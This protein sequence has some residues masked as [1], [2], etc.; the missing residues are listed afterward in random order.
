[1]KVKKK[2]RAVLFDLDGTLLNSI[3]LIKHCFEKVFADFGI[4][5]G[6]GEVM[7]TVGLPL[8]QAAEI[9]AQGREEQFLKAYTE[10]YHDHQA[11]MLEL[12]PGTAET[13]DAL[14]GAGY[15]L[16]LVTSKRRE[17]AVSGMSMTGLDRYISQVVALEDTSRP[18][19]YPDCLLRGLELLEVKPGQAVYVGDSWYDVLTG[20]N[21]GVATAGV[22]WGIASREE[23][24]PYR[25]DLIAD[26]WKQLLDAM[27]SMGTVSSRKG[28]LRVRHA[29]VNTGLA[30]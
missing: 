15:R 11:E 4:P 8:R 7:K 10:F 29:G 28:C 6:N 12:F 26:D 23:M 16:G 20:K 25:P 5:W 9:Y 21:A 22:T 3:P 30:T 14:C 18:K 17:P 2:L 1:V 13:L 24:S 19:P 27:D